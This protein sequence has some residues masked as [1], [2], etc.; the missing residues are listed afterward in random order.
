MNIAYFDCF[1]GISGD[2]AIAAMLDAG[3]SFSK[4][5]KELGKLGLKG[6]SLKA[7]KVM[8]GS[9]SGTRFDCVS[10]EGKHRHRSVAEIFSIIDRS[11]LGERVK[12]SAKDTF[13]NIA[14]AEAR[15]H[16]ISGIRGVRLHELGSVDSI[17]DIVG[18]AIALEELCIDEVYSSDIT[19]G[20]AVAS[21]AH[22][23]IPIPAP[24]ALELLKGAP[25]SVSGIEAELVTPTGAGILKTLSKGFGAM[26]RMKISSIGYG[27]GSREIEEMPNMLRV[28]IGE[29]GASFE[30][31]RVS[32]VETNI[33][34]MNPQHFEYLYERLF[35]A[36]ALDVYT[37][38]VQMKK[39]RPAFKLT[40]IC[41]PDSLERI[42]DVIFR[43]TTTTGLRFQET[44]RLKLSRKTVKVRTRYGGLD[45]KVSSGPG[46]IFKAAPEHDQ[47]VRAARSGGVPLRTVWEAAGRAVKKTER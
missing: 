35:G 6:Y 13:R 16:G 26:P 45:V 19:M 24:A 44:G 25:V 30:T 46:G 41:G 18:V 27:A 1:S 12:S 2:M 7:S 31:D 20:R 9:M 36:G 29:A 28:V 10:D 21:T 32:V 11:S 42:A 33:D 8:R 15:I 3:L 34:D 17:V 4:L 14:A 40:V 23:K 43:E 39:T 47:C 37:T 38:S 5:S 22:G